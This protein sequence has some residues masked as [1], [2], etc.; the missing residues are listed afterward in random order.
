MSNLLASFFTTSKVNLVLKCIQER[1]QG[2]EYI[3]KDLTEEFP[4]LI[5]DKERLTKLSTDLK[6]KLSENGKTSYGD[7]LDQ[8]TINQAIAKDF[9]KEYERILEKSI[10]KL[11]Q[12]IDTQE[13][14]KNAQSS[15]QEKLK[16]KKSERANKLISLLTTNGQ[17]YSVED[18]QHLETCFHAY[19][20]DI[21]QRLQATLAR[22]KPESVQATL[23]L[24]RT[25]SD[26]LK[27][28]NN[29]VATGDVKLNQLNIGPLAPPLA[30][31]YK[32]NIADLSKRLKHSLAHLKPGEKINIAVSVP[33]NRD[34]SL[35]RIAEL[36][37]QYRS[38]LVA[39]LLLIFIQL[40]MIKKDD[41]TRVYA[42]I[43]KLAMDDGIAIDPNEIKFKVSSI[44]NDGKTRVLAEELSPCFIQ[45][46]KQVRQ[47]FD[48]QL[49]QKWSS[50]PSKKLPALKPSE[51][52]YNSE[53]D[54][55]DVANTSAPS[56]QQLSRSL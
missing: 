53:E 44:D 30:P 9:K 33:L 45:Q 5:D 50:E 51:S 55:E 15:L 28:K 38:S 46:L 27:T 40:R 19:L 43:K 32:I 14:I 41:E 2:L 6:E 7:G 26:L 36:G 29:M 13:I 56:P 31:A 11:K 10:D 48:A 4:D 17:S 21:S 12:N 52:G 3:K 37:L 54:D 25:N 22:I 39:L 24:Y 47:E 23:Q 49:Q 34:E 1:A 35:K 18:K 8:A 42:A 16:Q 20:D